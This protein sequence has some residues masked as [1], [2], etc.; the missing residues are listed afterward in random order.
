M[1]NIEQLP[2]NKGIYLLILRLTEDIEIEVGKL[3]KQKFT[4]GWWIYVG[5][6]Y[7]TGG[8]KARLKHHISTSHKRLH[9]HMDYFRPHAV[10]E[11]IIV[12]EHAR[13]YEHSIA[14]YLRTEV[15]LFYPHIGFGASDCICPSH[16]FYSS[17]AP[18]ILNNPLFESCDL[19][20]L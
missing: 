19:I 12:C 8:L 7:G 20:S 9:W 17:Q 4:S 13:H 6:A 11:K 14:N 15:K 18:E 3:G 2:T 5:S 1:N 16:F 10:L